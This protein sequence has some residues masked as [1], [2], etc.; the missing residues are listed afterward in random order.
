M[1]D[2]MASQ[3]NQ[4]SPQL[5]DHGQEKMARSSKASPPEKDSMP[6]QDGRLPDALRI[7][8]L[9]FDSRM[10]ERQM[11][12]R[13]MTYKDELI[14]RPLECEERYRGPGSEIWGRL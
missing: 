9:E 8:V 3:V 1:F 6:S 7:S 11:D 10:L 4:D 2:K 5:D 14:L 13:A 12:L